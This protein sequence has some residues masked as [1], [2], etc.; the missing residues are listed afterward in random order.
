MAGI[1][2]YAALFEPTIQLLT[3]HELPV[4]LQDGPFLLNAQKTLD[5]PQTLLMV[6]ERTKVMLHGVKE[7]EFAD[8]IKTASRLFGKDQIQVKAK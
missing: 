5:T 7:G 8:T 4:S 2:L 3:L 6:A 1:C